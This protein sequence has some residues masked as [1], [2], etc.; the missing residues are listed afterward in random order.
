MRVS[1][2]ALELGVEL[3]G[4][5]PGMACYFNNFDKAVVSLTATIDHAVGLHTFA[6][7]VVELVAMT[8][9]LENNR[10]AI[11]LLSFRARRQATDPVAQAHGA[12]FV[13]NLA[14]GCHQV[15]DRMGGLRIKFGTIG[16]IRPP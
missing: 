5:E 10:F 9:T 4:D 11:G 2:T 3:R 13:G 15:D 16:P 1:R 12:A 14:L 8:M 6:I 7:L